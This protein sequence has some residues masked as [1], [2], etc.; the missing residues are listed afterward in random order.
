MLPKAI[1]PRLKSGEPDRRPIAD[2]T[3]ILRI[4]DFTPLSGA[5]PKRTVLV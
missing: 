1:I 2:V 3:V 4:V 5:G